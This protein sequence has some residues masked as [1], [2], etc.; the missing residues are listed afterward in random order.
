MFPPELHQPVWVFYLTPL[1]L[2][3]VQVRQEERREEGGEGG[4]AQVGPAE[5]PRAAE[6]EGRAGEVC[7]RVGVGE[8]RGG[9]L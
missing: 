5:R 4:S 2:R 8:G 7:V 1:P 3:S 9:G 6:D